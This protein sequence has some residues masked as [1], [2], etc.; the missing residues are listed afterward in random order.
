MRILALIGLC[1]SVL[2]GLPALAGAQEGE[3]DRSTNLL[4][5]SFSGGFPNGPSRNAAVSHD[6]RTARLIAY[7]SDA[8]DIVAGD[9]NAGTDVFVVRREGD[10]AGHGT[11][12]R[13]GQTELVSSGIGGAP[14]NGPSF[15]AALDGDSKHEPHC[16]AFVSAA[17]NL[18]RGDTNGKP[19][20]FVK[21]LR[22]GRLTRVSVDARGRQ[23]RGNTTEVAIDGACER[24][25]FV[26]DSGDLALGRTATPGWETA[27]TTKPRGGLRQVYVRVLG[28]QR[29]DRGFAGLTFLASASRFGKAA[30]GASYGAT[31]A[32]AGKAVAFVSEA[33]NLAPGDRSR[34]SDVYQRS[35]ERRFVHLGSGRGAQALD[36]D[37]RLVSASPGGRAGNGPSRSPS[38]TDSGRFVAFE[39]DA[40]DLLSGDA[41]GVT[42]I[43]R[44]DLKPRRVAQRWVS[45]SA[46]TGI[47]NGPSSRPAISG[48]GEFVL[49]DSDAT[50]LRPRPDALVDQNG[51][52]DVFLW[53]APTGNVS[54]E[55]RDSAN[56]LLPSASQAPATSSRGNY[57]PFESAYPLID[58]PLASMVAPELVSN[59]SLLAPGLIPSLT[60]PGTLPVGLPP[61]PGVSARVA[62]SSAGP[63]ARAAAEPIPALQQ[64]YLRYLGPK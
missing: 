47:G 24:V 15:A 21:D 44:A 2:L 32:P 28:G 63:K 8:S 60:V 1:S 39:T 50:N 51:Q 6:Q 17:S 9:S 26:S 27:R 43:A 23:S 37:T 40:T 57:V 42:D 41:N 56:G 36:F 53:N 5:R 48:A 10:T 18:V 55:S 45:R 49:F 16:V 64:V 14:A 33:T 3:S 25:A 61:V 52:R 38:V 20:A 58:I 22:T 19:D 11:P 31:F 62:R 4:S 13:R 59:P 35:F 54:L 30:N 29:L 12:W 7:E 34:A 46:A